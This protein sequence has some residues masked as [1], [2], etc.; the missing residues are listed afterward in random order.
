MRTRISAGTRLISV[1]AQPRAGTD[2][3][4]F[5][6]LNDLAAAATI[7]AAAINATATAVKLVR[8]WQRALRRKKAKPRQSE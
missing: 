1:L 3:F 4:D 6:T 5:N 7:A 8:W 2:M